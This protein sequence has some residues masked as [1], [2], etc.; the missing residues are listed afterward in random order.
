MDIQLLQLFFVSGGKGRTSIGL[1]KVL[2]RLEL[3]TWSLYP[4]AHKAYIKCKGYMDRGNKTVA[5][6][7]NTCSKTR[8]VVA[9]LHR[10]VAD[11]SLLSFCKFILLRM[12]VMLLIKSLLMTH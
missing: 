6:R 1:G 4:K 9:K 12:S 10:T 7:V 2:H 5:G 3:S 11:T 8:E